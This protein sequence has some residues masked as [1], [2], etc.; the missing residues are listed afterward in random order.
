MLTI[1]VWPRR[2]KE[3]LL[4]HPLYKSPSALLLSFTIFRSLSLFTVLIL[5]HRGLGWES[6]GRVALRSEASFSPPSIV[7]DTVRL[8]WRR[9]PTPIGLP[10]LDRFPQFSAMVRK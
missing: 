7:A 1:S 8:C 3:F 4:T 6:A 10:T 9:T 2:L 5:K